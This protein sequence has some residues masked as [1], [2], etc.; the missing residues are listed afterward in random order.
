MKEGRLKGRAGEQ[1]AGGLVV[2]V[3]SPSADQ[4]GGRELG[5]EITG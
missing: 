5:L 4:R 2:L 3:K 1:A